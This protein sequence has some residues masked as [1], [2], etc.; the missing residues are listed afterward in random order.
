MPGTDFLIK[1]NAL[2][3]Q[4]FTNL[5]GIIRQISETKYTHNITGMNGRNIGNIS[6]QQTNKSTA[7]NHHNQETTALTGVFP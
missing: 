4:Y 7:H 5:I 3:F 1:I 2:T 6:L